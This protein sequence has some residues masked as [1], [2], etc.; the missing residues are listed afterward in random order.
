MVFIKIGVI[1][2]SEIHRYKPLYTFQSTYTLNI[3]R[4]LEMKPVY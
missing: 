1:L 4:Q 2:D 3:C